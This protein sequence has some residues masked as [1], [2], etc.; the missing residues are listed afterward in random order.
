[1]EFRCPSFQIEVRNSPHNSGSL[2][3]K[4]WVQRVFGMITYLSSSLLTIT[5]ITLASKWLHIRLFV[6]EDVDLLLEWFEVG[7]TRLIGPDLVHQARE[8]VKIIQERL[9]IAQSRQKS[10]TDVR[11]R[12][13][14]FE[15]D[16]WVYLKIS[17]MKGFMR[18]GKKGKLNPRYISPYRISKRIG[19]VVYEL[20]LPPEL[21]AVHPVFH[22]SILKKCMCDPSLIIPTEDIAIKDSLSYEEIPVRKLR[23]KEVALVK[24]LRRNHFVEE[25]T[26]EVEEDMKK[27]YPHLFEPEEIPNEVFIIPKYAKGFRREF[28]K[29]KEEKTG[30][31]QG[32]HRDFI[33]IEDFFANGLLPK[34]ILSCTYVGYSNLSELGRNHSIL[35]EIGS[36][37]RKKFVREFWAEASAP[38]HQCA[39]RSL[40]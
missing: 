36:K 33:R 25:P 39:S 16:D 35:A 31:V 7:E 1:M 11:R 32:V 27:R 34:S 9:K 10:Y 17:P 18:F 13:L 23:A 22:I 38:P 14:N 40:L 12:D 20:D 29:K 8:K 3:R 30:K 37:M 4:V 15:A 6:G 24:V 5:V 2:S 28:K 19:N 26:W 21:A